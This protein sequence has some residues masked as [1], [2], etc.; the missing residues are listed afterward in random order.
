MNKRT[1]RT[2]VM[3]SALIFSA[4]VLAMAF[5]FALVSLLYRTV[6]FDGRN[7]FMPI[8]IFAIVSLVAGSILAKIGGR[9]PLNNI[10]AISEATKEI[11]KGNFSVRL[12]EKLVS[13]EL[14]QMAR[15]FNQMAKELESIEMIRSDFIENVS[16][17][18]KTPLTAIEGYASLLQ[19]RNLSEE[20]RLEYTKKIL[21][22]TKRLSGLTS[23]ILL[24]SS[25]ENAERQPRG[26]TYLL[27]EQIREMILELE[28]QWSEKNIQFEI[29]LEE[30][31]CY[32]DRDLFAQ[33]WQ[34]LLSNAIKFAP[35]DGFVRVRLRNRG[36]R[37]VVSIAD[38]GPGIEPEQQKRIFEKFYQADTS[39]SVEGNGLGLALVKRIV[40]LC[41]AELTLQSVSGMGSEFTV[42]LAAAP[43]EKK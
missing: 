38:N 22:N 40:D 14:R 4:L 12:N 21:N 1:L 20:K 10:V 28:P 34:N 6:F 7:R 24:L 41:S 37:P 19:R 2:A 13:A 42:K 16:H 35:Q 18:F 30:C 39:H 8:F 26:E 25:I 9:K 29:D 15:S 36:G 5:A 32:A 11:A 27:D 3:F 17:E 33:V 31:V 43:S 23:S